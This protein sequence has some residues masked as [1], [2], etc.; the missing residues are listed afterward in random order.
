MGYKFI[1]EIS[2]E[3]ACFFKDLNSLCTHLKTCQLCSLSKS[4]KNPIIPNVK[5]AILMVIH[6]SPNEHQDLTGDALACKKTLD[7]RDFL[8]AN[9]ELKNDEISQ[10][11]LIKCYGKFTQNSIDMCKDYLFEEIENVNPKVILAMGEMV[12]KVILKNNSDFKALK[13]SLFRYKNSLVMPLD[14]L[15][16]ISKN[17]SKEDEFIKSVKRIKEFI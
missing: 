3:K 9:L 14:S 8:A 15:E 17:P 13:G 2:L 10:N 5:A 1:D 4:R 12:T 11:F 6:E 16:F 7:F